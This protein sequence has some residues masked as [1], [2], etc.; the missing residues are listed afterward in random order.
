MA[1]AAWIVWQRFGAPRRTPALLCFAIQLGLNALW[2]PLFFGLHQPGLA[3]MEILFLWV[4]ILVTLIQFWKISKGASLLLVPY[5][6]WIT[7]ASALNF[8][9][10]RL[11]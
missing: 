9:L 5:L 1:V 10:W 7:F 6:A 2:S 4:A 11:N 3:F 8:T